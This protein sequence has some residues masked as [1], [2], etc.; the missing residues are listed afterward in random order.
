[1][2]WTSCPRLIGTSSATGWR[3]FYSAPTLR[4][5]NGRAI[6]AS[7]LSSPLA[8]VRVVDLSRVLAG[9]Y[10]TMTLA[11]LGADVIKVEH[12]VGGDE[13]RSWGPPFV[14]GESAYFL[15]VNRGK[16]SV[17]LDLKTSEGRDLALEL[18]SRADVVVENFR[19]GGAARLGLDYDAVRA[20]RPDVVYCSISGFGSREP[21]GR[22]GYDFTVQAESG[23]MSITGEADGEPLKVGVAVVDVLTGLN[24]AVAIL[25]AL[26]Q[27]DRTGEG[28]RI[29]LSLL[30]SAFAALVN[31]AAGALV[32]GD[33][34]AR[35]GNAHP[36]IVP[37]QVFPTRDGR[38]AV[39]AANDG[40]YR[41][42]CDAID[43][44]DLA[45]DDR[46]STNDARVSNRDALIPEL[47]S[48]FRQRSTHEWL[49]VM[50]EAG[51][52][53]GEIRDVG[54]AVRDAGGATV[55]VDHP[56]VGNLPLVRA[57]FSFAHGSIAAPSPP[58]LLGEHSAEVLAELGVDAERVADLERRGVTTI[59][60]RGADRR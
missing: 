45:D 60:R 18:C 14:G 33:E 21:L 6:S 54:A 49:E 31:V 17:A 22:P 15:S 30:D 2:E 37:Y 57:P 24:A 28:E 56:T 4:A 43:R 40:L 16:R 10:A 25:A 5:S 32:T 51:V 3:A 46:Y 39:A 38:L 47:E 12:P 55:E 59:A 29:E 1:V 44:R 9:P 26:Q 53:A 11:D 50:L 19:A 36:N 34:P 58:P 20:R 7:A 23:L 35:Y 41:R 48:V 42:L 52:P 8:D 27:R 13:T